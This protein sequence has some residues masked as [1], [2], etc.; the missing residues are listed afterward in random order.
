VLLVHEPGDPP[1]RA[2]L[3]RRVAPLEQHDHAQVVHLQVLLQLEQLDLQVAQLRPGTPLPDP[4]RAA[5][6][7]RFELPQQLPVLLDQL[8]YPQRTVVEHDDRVEASGQGT[9]PR[10]ADEVPGSGTTGRAAIGRFHQRHRDRFRSQQLDGR[11]AGTLR[12]SC[13]HP[14]YLR[15]DGSVVTAPQCPSAVH[16]IGPAAGT[17]LCTRRSPANSASGTRLASSPY[18]G[19]RVL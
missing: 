6:A 11:A 18:G 7:E 12:L 19:E 15:G 5:A 3:A 9:S 2:A 8:R 17:P 10:R 16:P 4:L 1:D 13:G 14:A